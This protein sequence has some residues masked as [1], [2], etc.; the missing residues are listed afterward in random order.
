[1]PIYINVICCHRLTEAKATTPKML[2]GCD[3][4]R[5]NRVWLPLEDLSP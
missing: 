1:M 2:L 3:A 5:N 4:R